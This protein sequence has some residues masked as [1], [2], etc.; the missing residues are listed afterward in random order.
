[1]QHKPI[2]TFQINDMKR[3]I[4]ATMVLAAAAVAAQAQK[5]YQASTRY[6]AD[7]KLYVVDNESAADIV[8]FRTDKADDSKVGE[9]NG[10]W[11][12]CDQPGQADKKVFFVEKPYQADIKVFFTDSKYRAGWKDSSKS[13]LMR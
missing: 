9:N 7:V 1:M 12:F 4:T 8:V 11:Y 10:T 6:G 5:V 13:S 2:E 3:F